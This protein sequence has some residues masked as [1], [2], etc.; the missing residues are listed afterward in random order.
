MIR[1][2]GTFGEIKGLI[3]IWMHP[4]WLHSNWWHFQGRKCCWFTVKT[5]TGRCWKYTNDW[6]NE[7]SQSLS[8]GL[9]RLLFK[10]KKRTVIYWCFWM[11]VADA[12]FPPSLGALPRFPVVSYQFSS[13]NVIR[14]TIFFSLLQL[15]SLL[16][17]SPNKCL[18]ISIQQWKNIPFP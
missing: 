4:I 9:W 17:A 15:K 10:K 1:S 8:K 5:C 2:A 14:E 11:H 7:Y 16:Q 6:E 13:K 12:P 3:Y 18:F